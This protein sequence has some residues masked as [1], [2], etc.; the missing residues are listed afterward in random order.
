MTD[1]SNKDTKMYNLILAHFREFQAWPTHEQL[2]NYASLATKTVKGILRTLKSDG[3]IETDYSLNV[4]GCAFM[5]T[6]WLSKPILA[7]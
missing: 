6:N 4:T 1:K 2:C 3:Y 7:A 5:R